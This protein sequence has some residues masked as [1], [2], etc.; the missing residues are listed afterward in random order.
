MSIAVPPR[1][2]RNLQL[3]TS[4]LALAASLALGSLLTP[5]A[6]QAQA[7]P[8]A[9]VRENIDANGVDLFTG[10]LTV[11]APALTLGSEGSSLSYY[12]WN[13][14]GGWSDNV[15]AFLNLSGSTMTVSLGGVSDSFSVSGSTYASTEGNG[16][17]LTYNSTTHIYTYT[18]GDGTVI[19]FDNN[20]INQ[21]VTYSNAGMVIDIVRP[22]GEKLT[23]AYDQITYCRIPNAGGTFCNATGKAYRVSSVTNN[24]GYRLRPAYGSYEWEYNSVDGPF[25]TQPDFA[26][27]AEVTGVN[28][29]NLAVSESAVQATQ[30]FGYTAPGGVTTYNVT[31]AEGR[32]TK[33]R[34]SG[35]A[36]AG[37]TFPGHTSEDVTIGYTSGLV[38]SVARVGAGTTSYTRSDAN[39][40][41]TVT[42]TPPSGV[43]PALSSVVYTF[44]IAKQRMKSVTVNDGTANRTTSFEYDASGRL[45]KTTYPEGNYVELTYSTDGRGNVTQTRAVGKP[46]SGATDIVTSA[47][48]TGTGCNNTLVPNQP[49]ST[50]D[51]RN[52][53]TEYTYDTTH[54]GLLTVTAPA[55]ETGGV[56]PKTTYVYD[57][58]QAYYY[59][60]GS[61]VASG[62]PAHRLVSIA[63]CRTSASCA[64]GTDERKVTI[65]YGPQTAGT[66]NNLLPV[67]STLARGDGALAATTTMAY[68]SLGRIRT[69]DGPLSADTT[70][71]KFNLAGQPLGAIGPDPD[72]AGAALFPAVRY[73]Y[74][75]D[76]Q[77]DYVQ[78]GTA[79]AQSDSALAGISE[80]TRSTIG[81]DTYHR[82]VRQVLSGGGS[83]HQV[84]DQRYD[85]L[86]RVECA[87]VRMENVPTQTGYWGSLP[88]SCAPTQTGS[89]NGP[90]RVTKTVYDALGRVAQVWTGVGT[91][92]E[93]AETS[94][95]FTPNGRL[96]TLTDAEGNRTTYAY[97]GHDRLGRTYFPSP[98]TDYTSSTT[99]Y[100]EIGYDLNGNVTTFRTRRIETLTMEYDNLN[101]LTRKT[102]PERTGLART[103]TRDVFFDYDLF[104]GLVSACFGTTT[105][106]PETQSSDCVT[107]GYDAL[108]RLTSET[109]ALDGNERV[110]AHQYDAAGNRTRLTWP[111]A[112]G[113]YVNY[114]R[115]GSGALYYIDLNGTS[116]LIHPTYDSAGRMN[117]LNRWGPATAGWSH[118]QGFGYDAAS[119]LGGWWNA[120][121]GTSHDLGID[122]AYNPARQIAGRTA[123]NDAYAFAATDFDQSLAA[124]GLN[125]VSPT[126]GTAYTY[127]ANGN[128]TGNGTDAYV[129]DVENRLVTKNGTGAVLRYDPLGRLYEL[130]AGSATTRFLHDGSDL[131]AEYSG[132]GTLLRRHVHGT[133]AGDDPLVTF[134]GTGVADTARKY[135]Y[136]DER[137]SIVAVTNGEGGSAVVNTYDAYGRPGTANTGRFGYT[138]QVWLTELGLNY[139]KARMYSPE[140]GRFLQT[141]PI[142]YGDGM[143]LYA[144]VGG[145]PVNGV[146]PSGKFGLFGTCP[147]G[148]RCEVDGTDTDVMAV[149]VASELARE[150]YA[151]TSAI[152]GK[153]AQCI[154]TTGCVEAALALKSLDASKFPSGCGEATDEEITVCGTRLPAGIN[155]TVARD[156]NPY[157]RGEGGESAC[158]QALNQCV[159]NAEEVYDRGQV[160][161][162]NRIYL[163]CQAS[164]R[165]CNRLVDLNRQ[166]PWTGGVIWFPA[167]S[168]VVWIVPGVGP[169]YVPDR[170]GPP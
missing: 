136:A 13:K 111:T 66:G 53:T 160:R 45:T 116:N 62:Q 74:R 156:E 77:V 11:A 169:V 40:V 133:S 144:Y 106:T 57:D 165:Q 146:D 102:V 19:R 29:Q 131:V 147:A 49:C 135:L 141:D 33:Y 164:Y 35:G 155:E 149:H 44:D 84:V 159:R 52:Q 96:L 104:G 28:G 2:A 98:T 138:G 110:L 145:D 94:S 47:S 22:D 50:T 48:Y 12:R 85:A 60:N 125:Q 91:S 115:H 137:G 70:F 3:R 170:R 65:G 58:F 39:G 59:Q 90:D 17:T 32:Q 139:Y 100:E 34:M 16:S 97:D 128:L 117:Y 69:V 99:D 18:R 163:Q 14:G 87:I 142:G 130:V 148:S 5:G 75:A 27:W 168:G 30:A 161:D 86:G 109:Q 42:V 6:A 89:A 36:V 61:I 20:A 126:S 167:R 166:R 103:H 123:S 88:T 134:E 83:D 76:G 54:G 124:N 37:I 7:V 73:T 41:R 82:P 152:A 24:Y 63:S 127:D 129:Y 26:A 112:N 46:S 121:S 93:A 120:L 113:G 118:W 105:A 158:G 78:S 43:T 154:L 114:N 101:R 21:S 15:M 122:L 56:R 10:K 1:S 31:D 119:R 38:T 151:V 140:L 157:R 79:T 71:Y 108:G 72:G 8:A 107:G 51:A 64:G 132:A 9:P 80:L 68:D 67:T 23:F 150:G 143:N 92:A 55:A 81:Y 25:D 4:R 95:T 153:A 162:S